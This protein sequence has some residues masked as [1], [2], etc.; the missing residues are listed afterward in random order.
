MP[1]KRFEHDL[2]AEELC[3]FSVGGPTGMGD[4]DEW[5]VNLVLLDL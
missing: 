3:V 4:V 2:E 5:G 1:S